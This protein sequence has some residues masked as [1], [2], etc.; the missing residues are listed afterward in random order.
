MTSSPGQPR[1]K[2]GTID[3]GVAAEAAR[4]YYLED[5]SKVAIGEK[6]ALTRFQVARLLQHARRVG[7]VSIKVNTPDGLNRP[8]GDRV[9]DALGIQSAHVIDSTIRHPELGSLGEVMARV[10]IELVNEGDVVGLTWSQAVVAMS[11]FLDG[12]PRCTAV[13]LAGQAP[14]AHALPDSAEIVRRAA[15]VSGGTAMPLNSPMLVTD[16]SAASS[17][18][19]QPQIANT[20]ELFTRLDAAVVS[21]GAWMPNEST[22][23]DAVASGDRVRAQDRGVVGE[24]SGRLF[25]GRGEEV[26]DVLGDRIVGIYLDQLKRASTIICAGF[27]AVRA[28]ATIA[29]A[30]GGY[31]NHLVVDAPLAEA[32]LASA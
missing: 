2:G 15:S 23:Y 14:S 17:I 29:A 13:Q 20:V 30:R 7:I 16:A 31:A 21:V 9:A 18:L 22:V 1:A 6:L 11:Q 3:D 28:Q 5:E 12:L 27:G 19:R 8:L 4:L 24:I 26:E 10:L 32:I 25:N